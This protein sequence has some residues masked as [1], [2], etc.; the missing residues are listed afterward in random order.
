MPVL[1]DEA[2]RVNAAAWERHAQMR[3]AES[4]AAP[5]RPPARFR[6]T[7]LPGGP[8]A[9]LF[10]DLTGARVVE[11][12]CGAGDNLAHLAGRGVARAVGVDLAAGQIARARARWGQLP[13]TCFVV[14]EA[15]AFL[16]EGLR[17]E[18]DMCYSVFGAPEFCPPEQLLP[19]IA[20]RL[21]LGGRLLFSVRHPAQPPVTDLALGDGTR[22]RLVRFARSVP[23]W[24]A[25]VTRSGLAVTALW[26]ILPGYRASPCCLIVTAERRARAP[27]PYI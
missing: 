12:G 27:L 16:D 7:Q 9:E 18:V 10:G 4:P 14:D 3:L 2:A 6:W 1:I 19:L 25:L 26:E 11:L 23:D 20:A 15:R 8:G 22:A 24:A 13:R 17:D 5:D 21:R